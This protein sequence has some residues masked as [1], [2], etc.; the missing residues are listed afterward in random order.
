MPVTHYTTVQAKKTITAHEG[1][2]LHTQRKK[3]KE[4]YVH[5]IHQSATCS[6][7]SDPYLKMQYEPLSLCNIKICDTETNL[8][9]RQ[10]VEESKH[11]ILF[12]FLSGGDGNAHK[13]SN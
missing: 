2:N 8:H 10:A 6:Q 13:F 11:T 7:K 12:R 9:N 5:K 4:K 3:V 1:D